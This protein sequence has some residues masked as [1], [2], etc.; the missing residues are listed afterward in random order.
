MTPCFHQLAA[1]TNGPRAGCLG[2]Q[3]FWQP[4][5]SRVDAGE[6]VPACL[7]QGP[8]EARFHQLLM[9][10]DRPQW[11]PELMASWWRR[12]AFT[13][14]PGDELACSHGGSLARRT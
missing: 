3:C 11:G 9:A 1:N 10:Q 12:T 13:V 5:R 14:T 6:R 7:R 4:L 2:P 8:V